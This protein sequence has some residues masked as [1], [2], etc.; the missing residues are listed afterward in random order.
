MQNHR[1]FNPDYYLKRHLNNFQHW[2]LFILPCQ[3]YMVVLTRVYYI[4]ITVVYFIRF[5]SI[6]QYKQ[7]SLH[8]SM[9]FEFIL[10]RKIIFHKSMLTQILSFFGTPHSFH[11][12][13]ILLYRVAAMISKL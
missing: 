7:H 4:F 9:Y 13:Y 6:M 8:P 1:I 5:K 3:T 2:P 10:R 12:S 11:S